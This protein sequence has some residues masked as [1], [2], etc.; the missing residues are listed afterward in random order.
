MKILVLTL[1][2]GSGHVRAAEAVADELSRQTPASNVLLVD[3]LEECRWWFRA[4]YEWPYW[5]MLRYAPGLWDRFSTA[6]VNQKHEGTAPTWA[7]RAGC[8]KVFSTIKS[9]Q[10]DL[11]V[12]AEVAAC[13]MAAI[14]R[15][16]GLTQA[17]ILSVIT[18]YE[19]EPIWVQ[20]E[21]AG[22]AVPD[23]H[24]RSE[25]ISWGAPADRISI[26][27]IPIDAAFDVPHNRKATRL[28]YGIKGD[29]PM[30]LLMGGGMGPTRMDQV[31]GA[32]SASD[33]AMHIVAVTGKDNRARRRLERLKAKAPVSLRVVGWTNEVAAL[34]QDARILVTKPGG[35]TIAEAALCSLPL[36]FFDPIPGAEFVNARRMVD[37]GAALVTHGASETAQAII[38]LLKDDKAIDAM[39]LRSQTMARPNARREIAS[40]ALALL[41]PLAAAMRR[42][43]A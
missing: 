20:P 22:F 37:G 43:T 11:I 15:R 18:D 26:C 42:R 33:T 6:R 23:E 5:L 1:S 12:A 3:A 10:P 7:F 21:V 2:F 19:S 9:F 24:V 31:V 4:G 34:M 14:A 30:V 13:E 16:L 25:M 17:P 36:V 29:A 40:L 27:G 8:P 35:L 28:R 32:L 41:D 39:A 38:S